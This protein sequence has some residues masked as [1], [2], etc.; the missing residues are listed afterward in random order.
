VEFSICAVSDV[1]ERIDGVNDLSTWAE[2]YKTSGNRKQ[3]DSC[4]LLLVC[5]PCRER[6]RRN[7]Q[8]EEK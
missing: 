4:I 2:F 5:L 3:F 1:V 8:Q 7:T 6:R